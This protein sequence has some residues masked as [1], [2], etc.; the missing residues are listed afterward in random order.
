MSPA[1]L[2]GI[3]HA[4]YRCKDAQQT[5][6]FYKKALGM[7]FTTAIAEDRVPSTGA[8]DPYMHVFLDAGNNNILAFFELPQQ[9]EMGRDE[10]TPEWVQHMAFRLESVE[11]L[12]ATKRHLEGMGLDVLGPTHH[13]VFMSIYFFDPNG[14]RVE[15]AADIGT[16]EQY[17][18]LA[19]VAQPMLDEWTKTKKAPHHADWLHEIARAEH[20]E[21]S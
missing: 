6:A 11:Q 2:C 19:R 13:G 10:H 15:L 3:H 20:S 7:R 4:A 1:K 5:V 16:K 12:N 17:E 14:H 21:V 8:H 18:E 9:P